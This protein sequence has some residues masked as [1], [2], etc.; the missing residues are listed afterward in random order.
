MMDSERTSGVLLHPTSLP[1]PYG[2]GDLGAG[3]RDFV[4]FLARAGQTWWQMLPIHPPGPGDSPYQAHSAFAGSPLLVDLAPL[5]DL[6]LVDRG[7]L[8]GAQVPSRRR[9][10]YER[11]GR[12]RA[13]VLELAFQSVERGEHADANTLAAELEAF[14][15]EQS[16]WLG[17]W[18]L[19][20]AL[21]SE[22]DGAPWTSWPAELARRDELALADARSRFERQRRYHAF[23]QLLF[24]RQWNAL[25]EH[26]REQGV[27]ILGDLPMFVAHDSADVWARRDLFR[28]DSDGA[29]THVSGAPPDDFNTEGQVWG[30]PLFNWRAVEDDAWSWW[31]ERARHALA[32]SDVVRLDH[33][34]GYR[35]AWEVPFGRQA[36]ADGEYGAGPG[37]A[38]FDA[39]VAALGP[40]AFVAEDLGDVHPEV[41]VLRQ[42]LAFPGM[43]VLQFAFTGS[44]AK[45]IHLPHNH[46]HDCIAYTGTHDND[47]ISGWFDA[48]PHD[49]RERLSAYLGASPEASHW[50]LLRL[51]ALSVARTAIAPVQD[52][53]GLGSR[54][55]TNRPGS[56]S[57]NWAFRVRPKELSE[58]LAQQLGQLTELAGRTAVTPTA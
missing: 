20:A 4:H 17:E 15:R 13:Q 12:A 5:H 32:H 50:N 22:Y 1:G 14:E 47:T 39:L 28:L 16:G 42:R 11:A 8:D 43:R 27:R 18:T 49:Q 26:A 29:P 31:I 6:G 10:D 33:F 51:N 54:A 2:C 45:N 23:V 21:K 35:A 9:A 55:R 3:A 44:P 25:R 52:L 40:L 41:E 7:V 37:P 36:A 48:L 19:Y 56:A 57:N 53:L 30:H 46:R 34:V 24:F 58:S 38:L